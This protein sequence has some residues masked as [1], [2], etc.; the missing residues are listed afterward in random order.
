MHM[1][2]QKI[3]GYVTHGSFPWERFK[4]DSRGWPEEGLTYFWI[5]DSCL[6]T[7]KEVKNRPPFE[8]LSLA[9]S[10]AAGLQI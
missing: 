2:Q 7:V 6:L 8:V 1:E 3:S 5:T 4:W 10:I 9:G